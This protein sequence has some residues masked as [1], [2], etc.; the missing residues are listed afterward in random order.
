MSDKF[1]EFLENNSF[2]LAFWSLFMFS[3]LMLGICGIL[4]IL[5]LGGK[6]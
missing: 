6:L 5:T 2:G 4:Y 1:F 3:I